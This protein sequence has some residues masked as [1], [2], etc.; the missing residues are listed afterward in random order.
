MIAN[1]VGFSQP[2]HKVYN[3]LPPP[4]ED[5]D[6]ILAILFTGPCRPVEAD[7]KR[8]PLLVRH[9]AVLDAL[10]WLTLNHEDYTDVDISMSN[11]HEYPEGVPPVTVLHRLSDGTTPAEALSVH[12]FDDERGASSGPCPFVV[13]GLSSADLA[14]MSYQARIATALSFFSGGGG[15][16]GVGHSGTPE[17]IY[18]NPRLFPGMFPWLF[19]YGL[20]GFDN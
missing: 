18:H 5:L 3:V 6:D 13:H 4:R 1:A 14:T 20:G 2:V 15:V 16:L 7:F 12:E 19:P 17:S 10:Q 8:T 11:L 9:R